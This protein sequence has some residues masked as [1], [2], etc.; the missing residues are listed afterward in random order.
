MLL[1]V[2]R[3]A[4]ALTETL[5]WIITECD[6]G[7]KSCIGTKL[8]NKCKA[9]GLES[10]HTLCIASDFNEQFAICRRDE[11]WWV[12]KP[13]WLQH[14]SG[15]CRELVLRFPG[16]ESNWTVKWAVLHFNDFTRSRYD[17]EKVEQNNI[18]RW[19]A[20]Q[21]PCKT[22]SSLSPVR[23]CHSIESDNRHRRWPLTMHSTLIHFHFFCLLFKITSFTPTDNDG[24]EYA[25]Q[26]AA[27]CRSTHTESRRSILINNK[28]L[29]RPHQDRAIF[30]HNAHRSSGF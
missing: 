29:N 20:F 18:L 19:T 24:G 7:L 12:M 8:F 9:S 5:I 2:E 26:S 16:L 14:A 27:K 3:R 4:P 13:G 1:I 17:L 15:R 28:L 23:R 22:F 11:N 6:I 21:S 10:V 25:L 30:D